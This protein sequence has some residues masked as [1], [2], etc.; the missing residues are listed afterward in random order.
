MCSLVPNIP[1]PLA[2]EDVHKSLFCKSSLKSLCLWNKNHSSPSRKPEF[3][4]KFHRVLL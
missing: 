1:R 3:P 2:Q 4:V